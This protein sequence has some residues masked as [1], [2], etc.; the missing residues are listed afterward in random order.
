MDLRA[1]VQA[2]CE[3]HFFMTLDNFSQRAQNGIDFLG[4]GKHRRDIIIQTDEIGSFPI[5]LGVFPSDST[6]EIIFIQQVGIILICHN[7]LRTSF[8][9]ERLSSALKST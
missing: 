3:V 2:F 8:V 4:G 6:R 9:H 5:P 1:S 7:S